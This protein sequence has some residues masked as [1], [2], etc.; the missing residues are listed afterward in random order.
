MFSL[1]LCDCS[2]TN[3]E[4]HRPY[5]LEKYG[6]CRL[7][8]LGWCVLLRAQEGGLESVRRG[9]HVVQSCGAES[10]RAALG[11]HGI[12][13]EH[14]QRDGVPIEEALS[15]FLGDAEVGSPFIVTVK[16][17]LLV[18]ALWS[19]ETCVGYVERMKRWGC[20]PRT[21][22]QPTRSWGTA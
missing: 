22:K 11:R 18:L 6:T 8:S 1:F 14:Q 10:D 16:P 17:C 4:Q 13:T 19:C 7:V 9:Y 15:E 20:Q 2:F 3:E 5:C 12:T 21:A